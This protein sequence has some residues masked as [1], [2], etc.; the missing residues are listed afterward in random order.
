MTAISGIDT[1][2]TNP[3]TQAG[4]DDVSPEDRDS[5]T[6]FKGTAPRDNTQ[7]RARVSAGE[8]PRRKWDLLLSFRSL[9]YMEGDKFF[10][11]NV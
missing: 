5:R 4:I 6:Q 1:G 11:F 10:E 3:A 9:K 8:N 7:G 2:F